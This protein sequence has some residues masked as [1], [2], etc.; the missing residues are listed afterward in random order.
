MRKL[1]LFD[2]FG[3]II[4]EVSKLMDSYLNDEQKVYMRQSIYRKLDTGKISMEEMYAVLSNLSG[5]SV[6]QTK[7]EW[8]NREQL[9]TDTIEVVKRLKAQGHCIALLSNA[10]VD[11]IDY[12]FDKYGLN[13]Y[14]D[15]VFVSA[16]YGCAKPDVEFYKLCLDG[17]DEQFERIYFTD[18]RADNL[19]GLESLGITPVLFKGAEDFAKKVGA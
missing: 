4:S 2:C 10:A 9:F 12:L 1:F 18:D 17:F 14:F 6:E 5:M 19:V 16:K 11:Y 8:A 7:R 15:K 3:V 13:K